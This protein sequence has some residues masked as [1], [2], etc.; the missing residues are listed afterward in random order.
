[1]KLSYMILFSSVHSRFG[2]DAT[3]EDESTGIPAD[4]ATGPEHFFIWKILGNPWQAFGCRDRKGITP[5]CTPTGTGGGNRDAIGVPSETATVPEKCH[6]LENR[7]E[8]LA[9]FWIMDPG[10]CQE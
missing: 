7:G 4:T 3:Y 5:P 2:L 8:P 10:T 6:N 1:M 9:K